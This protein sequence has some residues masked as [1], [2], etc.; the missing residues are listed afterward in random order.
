MAGLIKPADIPISV[1]NAPVVNNQQAIRTQIKP[2]SSYTVETHLSNERCR[3]CHILAQNDG[4]PSGLFFTRY[5]ESARKNTGIGSVNHLFN[6]NAFVSKS[7]EES[8]HIGLPLMS[9]DF[10]YRKVVFDTSNTPDEITRLGRSLIELPQLIEVL[11][12]DNHKST[13]ITIDFGE[14]REKAG[15]GRDNYIC[16]DNKI[17]KLYVKLTNSKVSSHKDPMVNTYPYYE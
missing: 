12:R 9:E 5:Q 4:S 17:K 11:A 15:F 7:A 6:T 13:C 10:V 16:A 2:F 8:T 1:R 3:F 14:D